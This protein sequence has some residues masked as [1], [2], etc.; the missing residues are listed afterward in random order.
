MLSP[1][2]V[3]SL[4]H[5]PGNKITKISDGNGLYL[6]IDQNDNK[7]WWYRYKINGKQQTISLGCY[8]GI[9]LKEA[10]DKANEYNALRQKGVNL[11]NHIEAEKAALSS[12]SSNT[13]GII[14]EEWIAL[15]K[16]TWCQDHCNKV[17]S[18]LKPVIQSLGN[19]PIDEITAKD[20]LPILLVIQDSGAIE[21]AHRVKGRCSEI[22]CYA[23]ATGRA[24]SDPT[25]G[26]KGALKSI[27]RGHRAA[28]L[29]P[30]ELG[31]YLNMFY[32]YRGNPIVASA[33]K[34]A[35]MLFVRPGELVTAKWK[36]IDFDKKE[37][38]YIVSKTRKNGVAETIVPLSP[39][40][41]KIL[42]DLKPFCGDS[43]YVFPSTMSKSKHIT[44]NAILMAI[45]SLGIEKDEL[46]VHGFRATARTLLDEELHYPVDIIEQ[47]LAHVVRDP[48]GTAYNRTTHLKERHEMMK[49]WSKFLTNLMN[50][51]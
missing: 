14:C 23:I 22:F 3:K 30:Q 46:C 2:Q 4:R 47:Q 12:K 11:K 1:S 25:Q 41:I 20:L 39:E 44:T 43:E 21:T 28:I 37:W 45:R 42:T 19:K 48:L 10:R 51:K 5:K 26:L 7:K 50:N 35:P 18:S 17:I 32:G 31:V 38:R 33:L 24:T 49:T 8:P 9:G 27:Q 15:K 6:I 36:D 34:L 13:F 40:V 29:N 16:D